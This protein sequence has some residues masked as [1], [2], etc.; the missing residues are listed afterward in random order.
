MEM[1]GAHKD[2]HNSSN[3]FN[4]GHMKEA[5]LCIL[6]MHINMI[7]QWQILMVVFS[8]ERILLTEQQLHHA[9]KKCNAMPSQ[10]MAQLKKNKNVW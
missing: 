7:Y 4:E 8:K 3:R 1:F 10:D 5:K 6:N 9:L 2:F